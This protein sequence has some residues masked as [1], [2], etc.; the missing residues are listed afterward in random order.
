MTLIETMPAAGVGD[1]GQL[2]GSLAARLEQIVR[3]DIRAPE[4]VIEDACQVAWCRLLD[5]SD[6]VHRETVM[7]WLARTAEREAFRLLRRDRRE[8]SLE[9]VVDDDEGGP[10][11]FAGALA[12]PEQLL[13]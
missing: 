11:E 10:P 4:T 13:G 3:L 2:Y 6:R 9:A 1:V 7:A 5:H 8:V 12:T